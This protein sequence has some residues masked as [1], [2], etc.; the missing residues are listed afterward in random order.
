MLCIISP[1]L[2]YLITGNVYLLTI[3][4]H[5]PNPTL[6]ALALAATNLLSV[7][8]SWVLFCFYLLN[9]GCAG[10]LLERTVFLQ[11]REVRATL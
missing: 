3:L 9:F 4:I 6:Y 11:F 1:E 5:S 8:M 10:S 7:S 2:I